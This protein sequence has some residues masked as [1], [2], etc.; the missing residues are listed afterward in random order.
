MNLVAVLGT[1]LPV[2]LIVAVGFLYGRRFPTD[3]DTANR[4]NM[5]IFTPALIFSAL[6]AQGFQIA[7]YWQLI[8]FSSLVVLGSGVLVLPFVR[9]L[10]VD[11]KTFVPPMMFTNSG[12]MGIP[13]LL[14]AF[15]EAALPAAIVL[16]I[17]ENTLHF[18][19]GMAMV[20]RRASLWQV[21]RTPM[22]TASVI[23]IAVS[24]TAFSVPQVVAVP[25]E[26][27]GQIAIPLMLFTLGVRMVGADFS[28]WKLGLWGGVLA[29]A[30]GLG[31]VLLMLPVMNLPPE[32]F[33]YLLVFAVLPPA[34]LNYMVAEKFAQEPRR[35]ASIVFV[36]NLMSIFTLFA[37]LAYLL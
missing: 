23:G 29:P 21:L 32:Q 33:A 4:L 8:V 12:N 16:F 11:W 13:I 24:L 36:A 27:L 25:I 7:D 10:K 5:E 26:M 20:N 30:S 15:G 28:D 18:T 31:M 14:L 19:V 2:F 1:V 22:I 37:V 34:V 6:T 35:V 3:I 9:L 17:V